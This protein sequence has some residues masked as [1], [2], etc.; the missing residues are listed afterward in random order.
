MFA[1][2]VQCI[3]AYTWTCFCYLGQWQCPLSCLPFDFTTCV[4][5]KGI[6]IFHP[7]M[8]S[9]NLSLHKPSKSQQATILLQFHQ[10]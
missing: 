3:Y 4:Q 9:C 1:L 6:A 7:R 5:L 10:R 2:V 8:F